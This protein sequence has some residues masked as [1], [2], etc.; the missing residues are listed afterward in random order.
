MFQRMLIT[1]VLMALI[2]GACNS[3]GNEDTTKAKYYKF[4]RADGTGDDSFIAKT[5]DP[6][7]IVTVENQLDKPMDKRNMF[8]IG[9]IKGGNDGYNNGWSWHFTPNEWNMA[10]VSVEVCDGTPQGV[11]GNLDYWINQVGYFCPWS[12]RVASEVNYALP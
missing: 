12:Y 5:S 7:V 1:T 10:E 3:T 11:E 2:L 6:D 9:D 8:I 4:E